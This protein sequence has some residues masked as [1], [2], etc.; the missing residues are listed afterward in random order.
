MRVLLVQDEVE[1]VGSVAGC[2]LRPDRRSGE[3]AQQE[4]AEGGRTPPTLPGYKL[5]RRGEVRRLS[6]HFRTFVSR[7][8][9]RGR[10]RRRRRRRRRVTKL[11]VESPHFSPAATCE[12][13]EITAQTSSLLTHSRP[14]CS[15][16][17]LQTE[18]VIRVD[19][20]LNGKSANRRGKLREKDVSQYTTKV[21]RSRTY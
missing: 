18:S 19:A 10:R 8:L 3:N 11:H 5:I 4:R 7:H 14:T 16:D 12:I 1:V 2:F 9:C 17:K 20:T 21:G 15:R 13:E 6:G